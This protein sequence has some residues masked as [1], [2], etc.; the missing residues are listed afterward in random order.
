MKLFCK[1]KNVDILER[2]YTCI[3]NIDYTFYFYTLWKCKDCKKE[4]I[5]FVTKMHT[6][7]KMNAEGFKLYAETNG[8]ELKE[9]VE[10]RLNRR[11]NS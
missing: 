5:S 4:G 6:Y 9:L 2:F 11:L 8:Y 10:L 7:L 3:Y 1:H